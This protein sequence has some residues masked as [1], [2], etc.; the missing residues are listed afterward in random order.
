VCV[1]VCGG[2]GG[3]GREP[4]GVVEDCEGLA[5]HAAT[6]A[7]YTLHNPAA[8]GQRASSALALSLLA[9]KYTAAAAS[10]AGGQ[11]DV[12][13]AAPRSGGGDEGGGVLGHR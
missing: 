11:H 7:A 5:A 10:R 8:L 3:G 1:C 13:C 12:T 6:P 9:D 2:G 4:N